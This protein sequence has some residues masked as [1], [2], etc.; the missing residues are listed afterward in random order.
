MLEKREHLDC[1]EYFSINI[2]PPPQKKSLVAFCFIF[3]RARIFSKISRS[4][5][6]R[7]ASAL[8]VFL[9]FFSNYIIVIFL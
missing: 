4:H 8:S 7:E 5:S 2:A 1:S 6:T 3:L 9:F